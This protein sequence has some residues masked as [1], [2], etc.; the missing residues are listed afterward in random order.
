MT[1]PGNGQGQP[2]PNRMARAMAQDRPGGLILPKAELARKA[3]E[4]ADQWES[5]PICWC[6][7]VGAMELPD[8]I[9]AEV[10]PLPVAVP[11]GQGPGGAVLGNPPSMWA[12][13]PVCGQDHHAA[14]VFVPVPAAPEESPEPDSPAEE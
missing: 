7:Q 4:A 11:V 10:R 12:K 14:I 6:P 8:G 1:I 2:L 13:C 9:K 3:Q 5:H